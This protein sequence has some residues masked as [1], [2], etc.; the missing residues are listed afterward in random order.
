MLSAMGE[1]IIGGVDTNV[2]YQFAIL[3]NEDYQAG[4]VNVDFLKNHEIGG[5]KIEE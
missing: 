2:D 5:V 1:V 4:N 3:S